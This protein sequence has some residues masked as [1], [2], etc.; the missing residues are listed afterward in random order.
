MAEFRQSDF[1]SPTWLTL[2]D[3]LREELASLH[4]RNE[5]TDNTEIET[6]AIRGEIKAIRKLLA[7]EDRPG[8][9][10]PPAL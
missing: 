10:P 6:A 3:H 8:N 4:N 2:R 1:I 9:Q 5:H 7:L